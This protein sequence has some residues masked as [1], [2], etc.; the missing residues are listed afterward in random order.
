MFKKV[1]AVILTA[2]MVFG[3]A[4]SALAAGDERLRF[5]DD[6]KF[7][8]MNICD[9]QDGYPANEAMVQFINEAID[10]YAPDLVVL[11]GDN[12]V[13]GADTK[14]AAIEE[15][16]NIFVGKKT[17]FTL[18][19]GNHDDEQGV[20]REALLA[21]YQLYGGEYCLAYDAVPALT[22]VG[23][24]NL[25]VYA[26]GSDE[27]KFNLWMFDSNSYTYDENGEELGYDAV[28]EDQVD[29]Y[30]N[31]SKQYAQNN[32]GEPVPAMAFQHIIVQEIYDALFIKSPEAIA[33]RKY[34]GAYYST[35]PLAHN[36]DSGVLLEWPCC[37]YYNYGQFD[38]FL[39]CGD[40]LATFS[41]HDHVNSFSVNYKGID[42]VNTPGATFYSYGKDAV[43]G[44]RV[45]TIDESNTTKYDSEVVTISEM[46]LKAGS[47][48][49]DKGISKASG[50]FGVF[51]G[52][53]LDFIVTALR[54]SFYPFRLIEQ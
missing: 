34:D 50:V 53:L 43:R 22:G 47:E 32:G 52:K 8:I 26:S 46:S 28:H 49:E 23:T 40:V 37:G 27:V 30:R 10:L 6:G 35:L 5:G 33:I 44:C 42:I 54:L 45:I 19:F 3:V 18:V 21:Y 4:S 20:S 24:H 9:M 12:T 25:P 39:E 38:A 7:V 15:I 41:G 36:I 48:L 31:L 13:G 51:L 14:A 16:C 1:L 17:K 29:W 11:G 2:L